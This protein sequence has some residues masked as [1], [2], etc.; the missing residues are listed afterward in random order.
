MYGV[1]TRYSLF[2]ADSS[3]KIAINGLLLRF[4]IVCYA[5]PDYANLDK[6]VSLISLST[7]SVKIADKTR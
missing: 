1:N 7:G 5:C 2:S 3:I 6:R 4:S